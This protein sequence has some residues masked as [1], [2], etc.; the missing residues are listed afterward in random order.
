MHDPD[1]FVSFVTSIFHHACFLD[2]R[3]MPLKMLKT[4]VNVCDTVKNIC[5]I[6]HKKADRL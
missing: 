5:R 6:F 4:Q 3:E 1:V 2:I